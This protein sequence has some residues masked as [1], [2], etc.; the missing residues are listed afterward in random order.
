[1]LKGP[2]IED[3]RDDVYYWA[4]F[5]STDGLHAQGPRD[6]GLPQDLAFYSTSWPSGSRACLLLYLL[7]VILKGCDDAYHRASSSTVPLGLHAQGPGTGNYRDDGYHWALSSTVPLGLQA[8]GHVF[9]WT[10]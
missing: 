5:Y 9:Y 10:S 2:A 1:M 3:Y 7:T 6:R 8:Q 4:V